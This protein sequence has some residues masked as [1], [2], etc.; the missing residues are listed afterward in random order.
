MYF[1]KLVSFGVPLGWFA[2]AAFAQNCRPGSIELDVNIQCACVKNP[3]SEQCEMYQRNKSMYDGKGIQW[4]LAD[5]IQTPAPTP[6]RAPQPKVSQQRTPVSPTLLPADTPFWQMLPAG[7]KFAVGMRPQWLSASPLLDQLLSLGGQAGGPSMDA[8]RRELAGVEIVIIANTRMGGHPLVLARAPDV[9]RAT[10]SERDPYRYVDPNTILIG[11]ANGTNAAMGRLFSKD[12]VNAE[13]RMAG[14]VAAW[15][16]VWLVMDPLAVPGLA[17]QL[18]GV[19]RITVGL[20]MR[21][22]VTMEA[23]FDTPSALAAKNLAAR[24]QKTPRAAPLIGQVAGASPIVEQRDNSVRLYARTTENLLTGSAG[25]Q[26]TPVQ[27]R[28]SAASAVKRSQ[29]SDVQMGMDRA[30]VE[31]VL[32]KPNSVMAIQGA[33]EPIETLIYNLDDKGTARVRTVNGK[34]ASVVFSD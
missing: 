15:S 23:W 12:P 6:N 28:A 1:S 33:D 26:G 31:V 11:D 4:P 8:V 2:A 17:A 30:A 14:R 21:D 32:G 22:G 27:V 13:A 29:V 34:V 7:T 19:T 18:Q 9:V 24:L 3:N 16:D 20:A 25:P 10:K 5:G